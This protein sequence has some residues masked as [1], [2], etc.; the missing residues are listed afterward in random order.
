MNYVVKLVESILKPSLRLVLEYVPFGTLEDHN[1]SDEE[2]VA[3][4]CQSL[5]A[6][7]DLH[8]RKN[9]IV[10]RDIKPGNI[11]IQCPDPLYIKLTDFGLSKA[12][13]DLTTF[14]APL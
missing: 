2:C 11:L 14:L 4:L 3:I 6:L 13:I 10:H 9:P 8:K 5:S 1:F 12:S 7:R